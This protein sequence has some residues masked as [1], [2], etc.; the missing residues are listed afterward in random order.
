MSETLIWFLYLVGAALAFAAVYYRN[1]RITLA[2][3]VSAAIATFLWYVL[4]QLG[5]EDDE[6]TWMTVELT[7]NA[8]F[9]LIFAGAGAG[10]AAWLKSRRRADAPDE[11]V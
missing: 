11:E 5:K 2:M 10:V 4:V 1:W 8:S 9:A 6:P 7:M 3:L